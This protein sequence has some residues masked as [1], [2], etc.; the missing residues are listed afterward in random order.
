MYIEANDKKMR[1]GN[2]WTAKMLLYIY[3]FECNRSPELFL[4]TLLKVD[5]LFL[6]VEFKLGEAPAY[7]YGNRGASFCPIPW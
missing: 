4:G 5:N 6:V 2:Y 1:T 7:A 3:K